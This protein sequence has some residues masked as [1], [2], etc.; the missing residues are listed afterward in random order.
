MRFDFEKVIV[1]IEKDMGTGSTVQTV[2][3]VEARGV[4]RPRTTWLS[5]PQKS[6]VHFAVESS[7]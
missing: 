6:R 2:L 7:D 3:P 4:N 5:V 1:L